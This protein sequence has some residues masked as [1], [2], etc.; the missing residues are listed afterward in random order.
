MTDRSENPRAVLLASAAY[1]GTLATVR[2]LGANGIR[3]SVLSGP[4]LSTGWSPRIS[5]A[6]WSRYASRTV[7]A[8][9]ERENQQFLAKLLAVGEADPGQVLLRTSDETAWIYTVNAESL[10]RFFRLYQPSLLA[11]QRI[12]DKHQ[13]AAAAKAA[14]VDCVPT[15]QVRSQEELEA[16]AP[17]LP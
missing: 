10:G 3:V 8:P 9:H 11:I 7:R 13:F 14:G 2:E 16:L 1:A 12:L 15:W 5:A 17:T 6:A 4:R